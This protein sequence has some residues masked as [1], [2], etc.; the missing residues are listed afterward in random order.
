MAELKGL[1]QLKQLA[2]STAK[3]MDGKA[4][5]TAETVAQN[6]TYPAKRAMNAFNKYDSFL[7]SVPQRMQKAYDN[8]IYGSIDRAFQ[9]QVRSMGKSLKQAGIYKRTPEEIVGTQKHK[10]LL[11]KMILEKKK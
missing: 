1:K 10:N 7:K 9:K 3:G 2:D 5:F 11:D 6:I 4:G 8:S